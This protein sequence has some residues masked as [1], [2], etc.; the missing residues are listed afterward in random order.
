MKTF[1]DSFKQMAYPMMGFA[2]LW[3]GG[4]LAFPD[5]A[6][7]WS[8]IMVTVLS[9]TFFGAILLGAQYEQQRRWN[10]EELEAASKII[11]SDPQTIGIEID[12]EYTVI[13]PETMQP[14]VMKFKR[15]EENERN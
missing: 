7:I 11:D 3:G 15:R 10:K 2:V 8:F 12:G 1:L 9:V 5:K 14:K 4:I 6:I 13:D